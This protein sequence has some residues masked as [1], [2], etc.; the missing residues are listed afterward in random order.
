MRPRFWRVSAVSRDFAAG[1]ISEKLSMLYFL[2]AAIVVLVEQQYILWW[3]PRDGWM[4][5]FEFLILVGFV[6]SGVAFCWHGNGASSGRD[7]VKRIVCFS[8]PAGV[9][10]TVFNIV[11]GNLVIYFGDSIHETKSL[12]EMVRIMDA[13]AYVGVVGLNLYFWYLVYSGFRTLNRSDSSSNKT[14]V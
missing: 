12:D 8:L 10:V 6:V 5:Y 3:G 9:Q 1:L 14:P 13:L 11:Y 4:F 2:L 7:F